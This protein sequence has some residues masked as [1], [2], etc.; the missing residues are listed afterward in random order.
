MCSNARAWSI[1][2]SDVTSRNLS[3]RHARDLNSLCPRAELAKTLEHS[4]GREPTISN[5]ATWIE[6]TSVSKVAT[7]DGGACNGNDVGSA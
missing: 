7:R 1:A 2:I 4:R 3:S 6:R 5:S